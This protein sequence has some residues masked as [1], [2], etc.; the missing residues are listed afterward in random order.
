MINLAFHSM[1]LR[2]YYIYKYNWTSKTIQSIWWPIY[3]QSL[4]KLSDDDKLRIKNLLTIDGQH[5]IENK[6]IIINQALRATVVNVDYIAKTKITSF[7]AG[8]CQAE[9]SR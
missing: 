1:V 2:E 4:S 6:N 9:H 3:F 7:D 8:Q 5:F